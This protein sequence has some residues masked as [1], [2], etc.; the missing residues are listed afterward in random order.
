[1][2]PNNNALSDKD[3]LNMLNQIKNNLEQSKQTMYELENKIKAKSK[4]E[5]I[6]KLQFLYAGS[7]YSNLEIL[8]DV[9]MLNIY[10]IMDLQ[11]RIKNLPTRREVEASRVEVA[12]LKGKAK[13]S[14]EIIKKEHEK[15][16]EQEKRVAD[17]YG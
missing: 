13:K 5:A 12:K 10:T 8:T 11:N 1:M 14:L 2:S 3:I 6:I 15:L 4:I 17:I 7:I 16:K 9:I